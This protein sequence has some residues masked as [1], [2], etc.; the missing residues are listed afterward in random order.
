MKY[1]DEVIQAIQVITS[2]VNRIGR[3]DVDKS[4]SEALRRE[5]RTLQQGFWNAILKAQIAYA[6][7]GYDLR[8]EQ[9]VKL[10]GAVKALA[11]ENNWD[12][13]LPLI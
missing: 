9:A 6:D 10:A 2:A 13:G 11:I 7:A 1:N 5:H 12:M 4:I 8:N 3:T